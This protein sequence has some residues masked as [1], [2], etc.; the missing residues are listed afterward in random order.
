M[1]KIPRNASVTISLIL[2]VIFFFAVIAG[3]FTAPKLVQLMIDTPDN[4]GNRGAIS[5]FGRCY[6]LAAVYAILVIIAAADIMMFKIL[7]NVR[8][9]TV[10]T[11]GTVALIRCVSWCCIAVG[12]L[13]FSTGLYFQ[14][15]IIAG[16][17]AVFGGFCIRVVKNVIEEATAIKN[18]NELTV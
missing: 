11:D 5:D 15:A 9:G 10:F 18:E 1:L 14:L 3:M 17:A 13:F 16:F 6:V 2:A 7:D 12:V 8:R 4:F